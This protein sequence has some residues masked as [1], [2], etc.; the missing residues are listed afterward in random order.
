M[1]LAS[2]LQSLFFVEEGRVCSFQ[3]DRDQ[4]P[5]HGGE[6]QDEGHCPE[7]QAD[8]EAVQRDSAE[9]K[10]QEKPREALVGLEELG[11]RVFE[12]EGHE[13]REEEGE[14]G[15]KEGQKEQD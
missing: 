12:D 2:D 11:R 13:E 6:G 9:K 7:R 14:K 10:V 1:D 15:Q 4:G 5:C 8:G 3:K